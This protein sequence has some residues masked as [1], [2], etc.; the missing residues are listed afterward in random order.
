MVDELKKSKEPVISVDFEMPDYSLRFI[1][2]NIGQSPAKN[3]RFSVKKDAD[4]IGGRNKQRGLLGCPPVD[5]GISYLVPGRTLKYFL[6]YPDWKEGGDQNLIISLRVDF[7]NDRGDRFNSDIDIDMNQF[8]GVL[9]DSFRDSNMAIADAIRSAERSRSSKEKTH[10][11][12]QCPPA[13]KCC[14]VC[15]ELILEKA[16]KCMHCGE[17][18]EAENA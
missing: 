4:W 12:L 15:G 5:H 1:V 9:F 13:K 17:W 14:P 16:K 7:E 11:F 8:K 10:T 3:I 2:K 6:G 18:I